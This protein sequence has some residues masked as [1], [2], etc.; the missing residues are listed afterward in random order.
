MQELFNL[1]FKLI[2]L[3]WRLGKSWKF[4][5]LRQVTQLV[6]LVVSVRILDAELS[7][8]RSRTLLIEL[9]HYILSIQELLVRLTT[10]T[11]IFHIRITVDGKS[12]IVLLSFQLI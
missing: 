3:S 12:S 1:G 6:N 9:E 11:V 8:L 2:G 4:D 7:K 5:L 10:L